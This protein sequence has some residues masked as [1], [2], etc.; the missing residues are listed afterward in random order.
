MSSLSA[1]PGYNEALAQKDAL[2]AQLDALLDQRDAAAR[3]FH[4]VS[5]STT[6]STTSFGTDTAVS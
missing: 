6:I 5:A 3:E 1:K 4:R 2:K